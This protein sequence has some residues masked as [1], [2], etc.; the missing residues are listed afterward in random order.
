M[1][2]TCNQVSYVMAQQYI[3]GTP[4][5]LQIIKEKIECNVQNL[6]NEKNFFYMGVITNENYI[7]T[8]RFYT[9]YYSEC[10][11]FQDHHVF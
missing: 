5:L 2:F 1:R 4:L 3:Y 7:F 8:F 9:F 6:I 11:M 10:S